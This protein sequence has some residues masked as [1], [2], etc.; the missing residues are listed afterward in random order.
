[1]TEP[2]RGLTPI[3]DPYYRYQMSKMDVR[4]ER[5]K[6]SITNIEKVTKDL[7]VPS[8]DVIITYIG[9]K[10]SAKPKV[11][12]SG[13]STRVIFALNTDPSVIEQTIYHFIEA[14][15]LC[16]VC[17]LPE[18][19][20]STNANT[21]KPNLT[22]SCNA[23]GHNS[24]LKADK[25]TESTIRKFV[26]VLTDADTDTDG[27]TGDGICGGDGSIGTRN[28][29]DMLLEEQERENDMMSGFS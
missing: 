6:V 5:T 24:V 20:Y 9:K 28:P 22:I 21:K 4:K 18:L 12:K 27:Q 1:M 11:E 29:L 3:T 17:K 7:K 16:P 10:M 8:S 13:K 2:I 25:N 14:F 19:T 15:V 23:C 26:Q